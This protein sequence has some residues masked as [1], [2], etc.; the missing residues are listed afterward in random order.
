MQSYRFEHL[1]SLDAL[2]LHDEET[3]EPHGREVLLRVRASCLNYRDLAILSGRYPM[4]VTAGLIPLSDGA[5]EVLAVG[6]QVTRFKIGDRVANTFFPHWQGG[7]FD[8][9]RHMH[10]QY[11]SD[12]DGWLCTHK[13][14]D[15]DSLVSIPPHLSFEEAATLP[16]AA[17]TAWTA[18]HG[19]TPLMPGDT[20]LTLGTG[21][22]SLFAVQLAKLCGARIIATTSSPAKEAILKDLGADETIDYLKTPDWDKAVRD[23]TG[24][25][26]VERT[27]EIG[28][29]GTLI[30]SIHATALL[31]EVA[32]IGFLADGKAQID[33]MDIFM[34][35]AT[36]R[37]IAVG[38]RDDFETMNR[39][40]T[41]HK[42]APK[43]DT[44]FPFTEAPDAWR[45]FASRKAV[46]K[47]VISH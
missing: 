32:V 10:Q 45:H 8:G 2:H 11:G 42:L 20:V 6:A 13:V 25:Q 41:H 3:P 5:G 28:G 30:K 15:E 33:F 1:R 9:T 21:G 44:V 31:G 36:I 14:V 22:V 40:I 43:I 23:L 34:S 26:G 16:C 27:I 46:G 38:S 39:A 12:R 35:G 17:V 29:P 37:R 7:R 4:T 24:G 18:L 19:A 47:V